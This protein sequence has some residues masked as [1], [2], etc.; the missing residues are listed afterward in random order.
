MPT[1]SPIL[2]AEESPSSDAI[3]GSFAGS[4]DIA[5]GARY[6]GVGSIDILGSR[7]FTGAGSLDIR[8]NRVSVGEGTIEVG[9]VDTFE[10]QGSIDIIAGED[11]LI[12][13]DMI[14]SEMFGFQST[15]SQAAKFQEVDGLLRATP[16][17]GGSPSVLKIKR[18]TLNVPTGKLGSILNVTL[19]KP[20][21][22]GLIPAGTTIDFELH[23]TINGETSILKLMENG[24]MQQRDSTIAIQGERGPIDEVSFGSI[25]ILADRFTLGPRN[26]VVMFDPRR[27]R[28]DNLQT[29]SDQLIRTEFRGL[30]YPRLEPVYGLSMRQVL[31]RAYTGSGGSSFISAL[32]PGPFSSSF[33]WGPYIGSSDNDPKGCG[34]DGVITNI[35]DYPVRRADFT[36]EGGWDA[37]AQPLVTMFSP[38]FFAHENKLFILDVERPLPHGIDVHYIPLSV[39]K[40]LSE[41]IEYKPETNAI[42]LTYQYNGNDPSEDPHKAMREVFNDEVIDEHGTFNELGYTKT[43]VRRWDREY[44]LSDAP[45]AVLDTLPLRSDQETSQTIVWYDDTGTAHLQGTRTTHRETNEYLYDGDLKVQHTKRVYATIPAPDSSFIVDLREIYNEVTQISWA[46]DINNP[47]MKVQDRVRTDIKQVCTYDSTTTETVNDPALTG[48]VTFVRMIPVLDAFAAGIVTDTF[49]LT[50]LI[51]TKIIRETLHNMKGN[52]YDVEVL[53]TDYI[54][55]TMKRSYTQPVTGTVSNDAFESKSRTI[56][57]SD[58][59]SEALIGKRIPLSVN[60][61]ELPRE[62]AVELGRRTLYRLKNPLQTLPISLPGVDFVIGRG[63]VIQGQ[64]RNN[65]NTSKYFVTGYTIVGENLGRAGHKVSQTLEAVEISKI[66]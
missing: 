24:K 3:I 11:F 20:S 57:M 48:E 32:V 23:V 5:A 43:T 25:D 38:I 63:S 61:Y 58:A 56:L 28:Y 18:F 33:N 34:F 54:N 55:N 30:I 13:A 44:Y 50:G 21:D 9:F 45:E 62:E 53:E 12:L 41:R 16:P 36:I 15:E 40:S 14:E 47:G 46:E 6:E 66:T 4:I 59:A 60:A 2:G 1:V 10:V 51:P 27:V 29:R 7:A 17:G 8:K 65:T 22:L 26:P 31:S 49:H 35:P 19:A 64:K 39:H 52:A 42:L 37:G